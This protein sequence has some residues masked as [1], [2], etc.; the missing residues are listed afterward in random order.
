MHDAIFFAI[1]RRWIAGLD[2]LASGSFHQRGRVDDTAAVKRKSMLNDALVYA[3]CQLCPL[4]DRHQKSSTFP[5]TLSTRFSRLRSLRAYIPSTLSDDEAPQRDPYYD[6][7]LCLLDCYQSNPVAALPNFIPGDKLDDDDARGQEIVCILLTHG[8]DPHTLNNFALRRAARSGK[9]AYIT[10]LIRHGAAID[11]KNHDAMHYA[12]SNGHLNVVVMLLEHG[13]DPLKALRSATIAGQD[14]IVAWLLLESASHI[15]LA[16]SNWCRRGWMDEIA[17]NVDTRWEH[18]PRLMLHPLVAAAHHGHLTI[19][20]LLIRVME[21]ALR[22]PLIVKDVALSNHDDTLRIKISRECFIYSMA[23]RF[24]ARAGH[25]ACVE[26]L[27]H[28]HWSVH[29]L[30]SGLLAAAEHNQLAIVQVCIDAMRCRQATDSEMPIHNQYM[31]QAVQVAATPEI[32]Q[33][34]LN[35]ARLDLSSIRKE[36]L[37][38]YNNRLH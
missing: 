6:D 19:L 32:A 30:G 38:N 22:T 27:I 25:R 26:S 7:V 17:F 15:Q 14:R 36:F 3:I 31:R 12:A 16:L 34:L 1:Q 18:Q 24:G 21:P 23:V 20:L 2:L 33:V 8:A 37:Q 4:P 13:G 5:K 29:H 9:L 35:Q 11:C 10:L 28:D